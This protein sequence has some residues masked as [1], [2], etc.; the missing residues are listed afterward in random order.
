MTNYC[1]TIGTMAAV[2]ALVAGNALA[3][4]TTAA[5]T[6]AASSTGI[7]YELHTG[8]SS[9][10]LFRGLNLGD[11]LVEVGVDASTEWNGLGF[12]AG[13]WYGSFSAPGSSTNSDSSDE[14]DLYLE[15]SKDLGFVTAAVGYINYIYPQGGG[16][17][18]FDAAGNTQEVYFSLSR[19]FGFAAASLTYFWEV[20]GSIGDYA[21]LGLSRSF[22]LNSCLTLNVG[23]NVGFLVAPND[24]TSWTTKV[25]LD[26]G[27]V[28]SAKLSPFVAYS[29]A[30]D[31]DNSSTFDN[32]WVG[33]AMLSVSF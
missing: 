8:Y 33:G 19:D 24:F 15:V 30:L 9:I 10:Y 23:S 22:E 17:D 7:D 21:E 32:E 13:A 12:S 28:E 20:D 3:G 27:F 2:S 14:L 11:D 26:Y 6:T 16:K 31:N 1:K 25:S 4:T 5:T 18:Y 29:L